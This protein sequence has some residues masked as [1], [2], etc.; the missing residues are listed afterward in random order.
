MGEYMRHK[1]FI[2]I[3]GTFKYQ[4]FNLCCYCTFCRIFYHIFYLIIDVSDW[5]LANCVENFWNFLVQFKKFGY[6]YFLERSPSAHMTLTKALQLCQ[7]ENVIVFNTLQFNLTS[8]FN[9]WCL[10]NVTWKSSSLL[11][12]VSEE[13][14]AL[15]MAVMVEKFFWMRHAKVVFKTIQRMLLSGFTDVPH[16][17]VL[18]GVCFLSA[19]FQS[20][21]KFF[22][23]KSKPW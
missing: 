15:L 7:D 2:S 23:F 3:T 17:W 5:Q 16:L 8:K 12:S 6:R 14:S 19:Q 11:L 13:C 22:L 21:F 4:Y 18:F 10:N 20:V 9:D 1:E